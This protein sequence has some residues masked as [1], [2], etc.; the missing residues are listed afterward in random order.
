MLKKALLVLISTVVT[1]LL[2]ELIVRIFIPQINEHDIMFQFDEELGWEFIPNK[3]GTI[4][5]EGG[6][7][8]T[9]QINNDGY[10]DTPFEDKDKASKI[11]VVGDSFVSNISVEDDAVFTQV[12]EQ[13]LDNTS[14]Y[15][16]GVNGYGQVQ[17]YLI[18]K[19][20]LPK[21]QPNAIVVF[22]YLRND[23]TDNSN[24]TPW[25][26]PR[27]TVAF[28]TDVPIQIIPPPTT[29]KEKEV[30][31]FYYKSH[32]Y[33][34]VKKSIA[35]IKSKSKNDIDAYTPPEVYTCQSPLSEEAKILYETM[36]Q[37]LLAINHYGEESNI[38]VTFVLAP[39]MVQV[40]DDLWKQVQEY[41]PSITLQN[42]LP[43]E[44]LLAFA[45][46]NQIEM[47]DL[48]PALQEA[49]RKGIKMYNTIEQHWTEEGN[50]VV[51]EVL[52]NYFKDK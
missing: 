51:A 13:Q 2:C 36:Q 33:R 32:L 15:N 10:R 44:T 3:K 38:P 17:E 29:Y 11:M 27:P 39:S 6:I 14:V 5:Y 7:N 22:I 26:Y 19:E 20:W 30:L 50:K 24:K 12:L 23:F 25:L 16:F 4:V 47:I 48:L 49:Q 9:I 46:A 28:D 43:N 40:E 42:D 45:K 31:P 21:I 37:L 41:D 8:Q 1:L 52:T 34:L 35:T 18:L